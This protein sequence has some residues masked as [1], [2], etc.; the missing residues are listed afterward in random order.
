MKLS[1]IFNEKDQVISSFRKLPGS[2]TKPQLGFNGQVK[3][4]KELNLEAMQPDPNI[5]PDTAV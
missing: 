2:R 3:Y 5:P 1:D 4:S